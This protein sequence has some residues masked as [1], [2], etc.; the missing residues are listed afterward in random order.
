MNYK[1]FIHWCFQIFP[2]ISIL[3]F[4]RSGNGP[5]FSYA[6]GLWG[7][8]AFISL[9]SIIIKLF[10]YKTKNQY[11]PR[12]F[13]T[14]IVFAILFFLATI[15]YD[16]VKKTTIIEANEINE[17]CNELGKCPNILSGWKKSNRDNTFTKKVGGLIKYP[18]IYRNNDKEFHIDLIQTTDLG[19]RISGGVGKK[20][21]IIRNTD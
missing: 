14:C 9:A 6:I 1:N 4:L 19:D 13:L 20:L 8:F 10:N 5:T 11:L 16:N 2:P 12:P 7:I 18:V 21:K 3:L 17:T 15:S